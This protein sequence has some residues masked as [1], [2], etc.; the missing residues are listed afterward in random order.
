MSSVSAAQC[1]TEMVV[2]PRSG[3]MPGPEHKTANHHSRGESY[4]A[5]IT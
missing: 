4:W 5:E 3:V 1:E 2:A